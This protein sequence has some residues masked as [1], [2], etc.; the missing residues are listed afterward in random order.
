[1]K[2]YICIFIIFTMIFTG[3]VALAR[4]DMSEWASSEVVQA[5]DM[6]FVPAELQKDYINNITRAEF[7]YMSVAY[8]AFLYHTD[9]DGAMKIYCDTHTDE[10]GEKISIAKNVFLDCDDRNVLYAY[11]MKIVRGKSNDVFDPNGLVTREE[12]AAMLMRTLFVYGGG[13]KHSQKITELEAF[14]DYND[15]SNWALSDVQY[16]WELDIMK[17]VSNTE[18]SPK[19]YTTR[20]QS[21]IAFLRLYNFGM[22]PNVKKFALK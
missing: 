17:G 6:G 8:L 16:V 7:A 9:V 13:L 5:I 18:F 21:I 1:M 11:T 15:I 19:K 4:S 12:A 2:K 10:S 14:E 22:H 3:T 20:E